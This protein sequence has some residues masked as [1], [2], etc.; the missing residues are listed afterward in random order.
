MWPRFLFIIFHYQILNI[1]LNSKARIHE[2]YFTIHGLSIQT[3]NYCRVQIKF[4]ANNWAINPEKK[5]Y[6]SWQTYC[7]EEIKPNRT[8]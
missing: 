1:V 5:Y 7:N 4:N 8:V 6:E 2:V 3:W